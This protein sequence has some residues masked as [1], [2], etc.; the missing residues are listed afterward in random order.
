MQCEGG[1]SATFLP[2]LVTSNDT[3]SPAQISGRTATL[4]ITTEAAQSAV[5]MIAESVQRKMCAQTATD[6]I[7]ANKLETYPLEQRYNNQS[8]QLR[9]IRSAHDSSGR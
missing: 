3:Q 4:S 2:Q 7:H 8:S 1:L 5:P 9:K 6:R